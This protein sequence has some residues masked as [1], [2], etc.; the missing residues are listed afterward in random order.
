[1]NLN[2]NIKQ[3]IVYN[4]IKNKKSNLFLILCLIN[5]SFSVHA[6]KNPLKLGQKYQG[7]IDSFRF[8]IMTSS[9]NFDTGF[10]TTI[11]N[12]KF[13]FSRKKDG[14]VFFISCSDKNFIIDGVRVGDSFGYVKKRLKDTTVHDVGGYTRFVV[15]PSGWLA[16][17]EIPTVY[18]PFPRIKDTQ[19]IL[20]MYRR[21]SH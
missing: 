18:T 7:K 11:N 13:V 4:N 9:S 2:H 8:A 6:Q 10:Y 19:K 1:M 5:F 3:M 14:I 20:Y 21:I 15:L 16:V 12:I 17:F